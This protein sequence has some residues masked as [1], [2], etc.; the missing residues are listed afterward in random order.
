MKKKI[1]LVGFLAVILLTLPFTAIANGP[2]DH[3]KKDDKRCKEE[4]KTSSVSS[5]SGVYSEYFPDELNLDNEYSIEF[6]QTVLN[7]METAY[8]DDPVFQNLQ[9]QVIDVSDE[10][11]T[12][13]FWCD[14]LEL[15][16][17]L[18]CPEDTLLCRIIANTWWVLCGG[19]STT[20]IT[21]TTMECGCQAQ[22]LQQQESQQQII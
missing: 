20:T 9:A 22:Q 6:L 12:Q 16:M 4:N 10:I 19:I 7:E 8:G 3:D 5:A 15:A 2:T 14:L 11:V 17:W 1:M 13:G 21:T 18:A